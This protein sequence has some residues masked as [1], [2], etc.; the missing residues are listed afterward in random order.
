VG[1]EEMA[2]TRQRLDKHV[3]AATVNARND[4]ETT[5]R[6]VFSTVP[7]ETI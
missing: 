1:P 3:S 6:A 4:T 2:V 5:G 7:A